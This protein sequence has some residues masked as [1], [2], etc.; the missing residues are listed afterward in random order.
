M[1]VLMT[2]DTVGGVWTYAADLCRALGE[3]GVEVTLATMGAPVSA[4]Q[5]AEATACR[6]VSLHE[7]AFRLEWMA[8]P[9]EDVAAAGEWLLNLDRRVAPDVIHLNGYAHGALPWSAPV[10]V[11]GHSCVLSWWRAVHGADAPPAWDRYREAAGRGIRAAQLVV[12]PTAAMLGALH[13]HYGPLPRSTVIHNGRDDGALATAVHDAAGHPDGIPPA[14]QPVVLAAGRVWD[15]SKNFGVLG[16]AAPLVGWP[17]FV[18][19]QDVGPG[20]ERRE[21]RG[22]QQLGMLAPAALRQWYRRAAV[23]VHPALY[24]PFGLAPLEAALAGTA[25]VLSDIPSLREVWG[26]AASYVDPRD[27][28]GIAAAV[29]TLAAQPRLLAERTAAAQSRARRLSARRMARRY[30]AAYRQLAF[31]EHTR[32]AGAGACT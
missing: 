16:D 8:E 13:E 29:N 9:W 25:L 20:G 30:F 32:A 1:K 24:E 12:A 11:A 21:L 2:A 28:V 14:T 10:L 31:A 17:I 7:G 3:L 27:A 22:V 5:R 4:A 6:G 26:N 19:G 18:A 23:F 15:E